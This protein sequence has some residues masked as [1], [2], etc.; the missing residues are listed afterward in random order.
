MSALEVI[1]QILIPVL[2]G[3]SIYMLTRKR[4]ILG[5]ALGLAGQ[6]F[7]LYSTY[8]GELWGMFALSIWFTVQYIRG[9]RL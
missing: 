7:W 1:S 9:L 6:P 4:V 2:S 8:V 3:A 5:S